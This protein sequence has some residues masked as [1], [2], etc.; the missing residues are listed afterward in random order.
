MPKLFKSARVCR[1]ESNGNWLEIIRT[2][3]EELT[4]QPMIVNTPTM[5]LKMKA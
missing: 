5:N 2:T 1:Q 4:C 3:L